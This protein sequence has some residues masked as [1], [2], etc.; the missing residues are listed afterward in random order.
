MSKSESDSPSKYSI[1][2]YGMPCVGDAVIK[3]LHGVLRF[4]LCR[5][6]G[7]NFEPLASIGL[8]RMRG[9]NEFD[10]DRRA[11]RLMRAQPNRSHAAGADQLVDAIFS[12]DDFTD[13]RRHIMREL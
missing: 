3:D 5:R 10:R 11:E 1:T 13:H 12:R 4:E 9:A 6:L 2:M 7:F 8:R